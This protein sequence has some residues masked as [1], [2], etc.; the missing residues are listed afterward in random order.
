MLRLMF[1]LRIEA[2]ERLKATGMVPARTR[3]ALS[4]MLNP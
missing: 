3:Q 4:V 2:S 1:W